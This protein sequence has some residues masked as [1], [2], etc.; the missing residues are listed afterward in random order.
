MF[1]F[2]PL[3][4]LTALR[5]TSLKATSILLLTLLI[6]S[7]LLRLK[8]GIIGGFVALTLFSGLLIST[9]VASG[10]AYFYLRSKKSYDDEVT[11]ANDGI[12]NGEVVSA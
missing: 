11:N 4:P 8:G 3:W 1:F 12:I 10:A 6:R 7:N 5:I 9:T 2:N